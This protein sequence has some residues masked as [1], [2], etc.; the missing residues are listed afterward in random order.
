[1][2]AKAGERRKSTASEDGERRPFSEEVWRSPKVDLL[3]F[4]TDVLLRRVNR[5]RLRTC[6][7]RRVKV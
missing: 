7:V 3:F 4:F 1:V 6:F 2:P 5:C